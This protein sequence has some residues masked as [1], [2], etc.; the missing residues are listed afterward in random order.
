MSVISLRNVS[1]RYLV[2]ESPAHALARLVVPKMVVPIE[3]WALRDICLEVGRGECVG[4][5][6]N[7]GSGKSTLLATVGR[8]ITPTSGELK[9]EGKLS[10]LLDLSVGMQKELPGWD[11]VGILGGLLGMTDEELRKRSKDIVEFAELGDALARPVKTYSTGM[12]MRLGFSV[13]LHADFEILV[14]DEVLAV[15]DNNFHRKC[16]NRLRDLN[17]NARKTILIASHGLGEI[18]SLTDRLVLLKEGRIFQEGV[19][20]QVLAAYWQECERERN[21]VGKRV[22]PL[23][24]VNPYGDDLGHIKIDLVRFI[25]S[26]GRERADFHTGEPLTVEVWF[27][28]KRPTQNP[29]FRI[30]FFRNDG[31]WVHGMNNYRHNCDLGTVEGESCIRLAYRQLNLLEGEYYLSVGVWPDEYRSFVS[32]VAFD[33]HEMS[34]VL[35]IKSDR[36]QGGGI[37]AQPASWEYWPPGDARTLE[38]RKRLLENGR[39]GAKPERLVDPSNLRRPEEKPA[40]PAGMGGGTGTGSGSDAGSGSGTG[41]GTERLNRDA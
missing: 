34:Y 16:I 9:V 25:D 35:R 12:T 5:I 20:E 33:I 22:A 8:I 24:A 19:T 29:L 7:N 18:A 27:S 26:A 10:T 13:A 17:K 28:A 40:A 6:G 37:V 31:V 2:Y 32:D 23:R 1:K 4:I 36:I 11:N 14:V 39:F 21:R 41:A 3:V 15:G 38:V 30:Q